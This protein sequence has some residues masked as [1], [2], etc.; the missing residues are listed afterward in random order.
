MIGGA[1]SAPDGIEGAVVLTSVKDA[2]RRWAVARRRAIL[3]SRCARRL[4]L[5]AGRDG[6]MVPI[7]QKD[8]S[9][10]RQRFEIRS[11]S[12]TQFHEEA[13]K[14]PP[15]AVENQRRL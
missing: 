14:K 12:P 13:K 1:G 10:E 5:G 8:W 6:R 3:D 7:E 2:S 9:E 4:L 11:K 15:L